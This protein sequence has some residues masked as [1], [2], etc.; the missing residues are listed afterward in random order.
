MKPVFDAYDKRVQETKGIMDAQFKALDAKRTTIEQEAIQRCKPA[1]PVNSELGSALSLSR[2]KT[3]SMLARNSKEGYLYKRTVPKVAPIISW[4]RRYF[5]LKE[6]YFSYCMTAN[7]GKHRSTVSS[8]SS[9]HVLLCN[10]KGLEDDKR[11]EGRRFCFEINTG[12]R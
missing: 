11:C 9:I 4:P 1:L 5:V 6:F 3:E 2:S 8:T 7:T 10:I 12:S